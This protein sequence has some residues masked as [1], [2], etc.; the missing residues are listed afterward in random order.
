MIKEKNMIYKHIGKTMYKVHDFLTWQKNN[1]LILSPSFQRRP[2]WSKSAKSY[3]IDTIVKGLPIPIIFI[4]EQTD[5]RTFEP[6]REVVDGQQRLRTLI[7]F[8]RPELIKDYKDTD[9]FY[10]LRSHNKEICDKAYRDLDS[11]I[12][13][14]ILNYEFSVHILPSDTEDSEVLQIFARM[15]STGVKLNSQELRNAKYF[16]LFKNNCYQ[17]A[18]EYLNKW[19]DWEIFSEN[20]IAR[21]IEVEET[22]DLISMMLNRKIQGKSQSSLNNL[23]K[24]FDNEF[25]QEEEVKRRFR[26]VM[27]KIDS[28]IGK[29]LSNS[30]FSRRTLFTTLF[31]FYYML[32]FKFSRIDERP[33]PRQLENNKVISAIKEAS[34][35]INIGNLNKELEKV[36]RG[37]TGNLESRKLRFDFLKNVY[38]NL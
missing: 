24:E 18:Y 5:I 28:T 12:Q 34:G 38:I 32:M 1:G 15:N 8:I 20:N 11:N 13:K 19:R 35:R 25:Q 33:K 14:R 27:E 7:S 31:T 9:E 4:R 16:G 21:M 36:L 26:Y 29:D 3:L 17:L 30:E 2:V 10:V 23:Y 37:G 6:T 22:S